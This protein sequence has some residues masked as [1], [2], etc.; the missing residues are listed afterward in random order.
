[1]PRNA[2]QAAIGACVPAQGNRL[3]RYRLPE[4]RSGAG[5][6]RFGRF[7]RQLLE[8]RPRLS[9]GPGC[10]TGPCAG[11][12]DVARDAD[13]FL[14]EAS[15]HTRVENPP[16]LHL[17]GVDCG[18]AATRARARRLM[19]TH[20]PPWHDRQEALAEARSAY[21]GPVELARS[22]DVHDL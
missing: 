14:A 21:D 8:R 5:R 7:D 22:G 17:T 10:D 13:L 18:E 2:P 6:Q 16:N 15:F 4:D 1:M 3:V 20:V 9:R 11:L 19:L 12:Y